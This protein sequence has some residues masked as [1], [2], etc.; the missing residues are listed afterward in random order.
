ME[1]GEIKLKTMW[2]DWA[3]NQNKTQ[4]TIVN[5]VKELYELLTSLGTEVTNLIF[6][7]SDVVWVYW[8]HSRDNKP[9]RKTLTWQF[10][11]P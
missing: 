8:K 6:A 11:P 2:G 1:F 5:S 7:N 10:L 3:L 4:T 9:Q